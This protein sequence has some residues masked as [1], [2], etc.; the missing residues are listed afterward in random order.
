[1]IRLI[2]TDLDGT[3]LNAEGQ[4]SRSDREVLAEASARGVHLV[5]ATGR[6]ARWLD[7]LGPLTCLAPT[8]LVSNGAAE[9]ELGTG[10]VVSRSALD[11]AVV[12]RLGDDLKRAFPDVLLALE[13]GMLFGSEP[14]WLEHTSPGMVPR[15]MPGLPWDDLVERIQPVVKLLALAAARQV[16]DFAMDAQRVIGSR[17]A[18]TH[19]AGSD[20]GALLEISSPGT[21]KATALAGVCARR[22]IDPADAVAFGDMPNDADMLAFV[23][24]GYAMAHGHASLI[25]RFSVAESHPDGGVGATVRRLL[26]QA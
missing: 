11:T 8:V 6:P 4:I 3:L 7:C 24:Q 13:E 14:G 1:M 15:E 26:D 17:A 21:T 5:I 10:N 20:H 2:A 22:G 18:V 9:V 16:D 12:R 25:E 19:S 23:G